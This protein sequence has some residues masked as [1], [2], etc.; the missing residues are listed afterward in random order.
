MLKTIRDSQM[1]QFDSPTSLSPF[2]A[3]FLTITFAVTTFSVM[4]SMAGFNASAYRQFHRIFPRHLLYAC[5]SLLSLAMVPLTVLILWPKYYIVACLILMPI[6]ALGGAGLFTIVRRETDPLTLLDRLCSVK[7]ISKHLYSLV[8]GIDA[9]IA[10]TEAL[11]LSSVRD[12]PMHEFD[13]HLPIST[14]RDDPL[15]YLSTLGLLAIQQGDVHAFARVLKRS[16]EILEFAEDFSP[17]SAKA[18]EYAVRDKIRDHVFRYMERMILALTR[19]S[20][21]VSLARAG[22]DTLSEFAVNKTKAHK[23]TEGITFTALQF[24]LTLSQHCYENGSHDE[25]RIPLI[26]ARQ[27]VQR[28]MDD[29]PKLETSQERS[30]DISMFHHGLPQLLKTVSRIGSFAIQKGDSELLYRCFDAFGWLGCSAVKKAGGGVGT[31]CLRALCQLGREARAKGLECFWD[32]CAVRPEDHAV[33]RI[34]WIASWVSTVSDDQREG[35]KDL[36]D[37]AYSRLSG[38][39]IRLSFEKAA[40]GKVQITKNI[41]EKRYVE[42]YALRAGGRHVDYSDFTFLKDLEFHGFM[43]GILMQGPVIPFSASGEGA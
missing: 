10:E 13:W 29:P 18:K 17:K 8:P 26:V 37:G 30:I 16:L 23:Q 42:E 4:F 14:Q 12:K 1:I 31:A 24:M 5:I 20:T 25:I 43:E 2:Y 7:T 40:D 15:N 19:D 39:E 9:R 34:D 36:L 11:E 38:K 41:S 28:G 35:W 27:I 22:V 3:S 6:L 21:A 32:K 33:E